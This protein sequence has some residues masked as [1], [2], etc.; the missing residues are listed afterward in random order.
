VLESIVRYCVEQGILK[1]AVGVDEIF[2]VGT[3]GLRG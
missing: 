2:A 3:H 1:K